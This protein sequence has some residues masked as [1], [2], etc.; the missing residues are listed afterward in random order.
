MA[1]QLLHYSCSYLR[2]NAVKALLDA[3]NKSSSSSSSSASSIDANALENGFSLLHC[4]VAAPVRE[5][6]SQE[7]HLKAMTY[8]KAIV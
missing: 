7:D 8:F 1:T 3:H 5:G 2:V 6:V 4:V